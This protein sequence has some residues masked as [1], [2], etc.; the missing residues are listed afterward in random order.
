MPRLDEQLLTDVYG[1]NRK[2]PLTY[3]ERSYVDNL[4]REALAGQRHVVLYGGSKQGKTCL[5]RN[6]MPEES[7]IVVQAGGGFTIPKLY[8][9]I[10]KEAGVTVAVSEAKTVTGGTKLNVDLEGE[11]SIPFIAKAKGGV[12]G[13]R[14]K[15][16][17]LEATRR[18]I[19]IDPAD[20][21]DV[22]RILKEVGFSKYIV[23]EDFHYLPEETQRQFAFDLKVFHE[24][25]NISFIIV[26]VWLEAD[27]LLLYNGDL[28]ERVDAINVDRWD[29]HDLEAVIRSGE[30]LLNIAFAEPVVTKIV[31]ECQSNVGI[32]QQICKTMCESIGVV[33]TSPRAVR[34][35]HAEVVTDLVAEIAHRHAPRCENFLRDLVAGFQHTKLDIYRW[36][37]FAIVTAKPI[38]WKQGLNLNA[39]HRAISKN[40][41]IAREA[42]A[43]VPVN[44]V[45]N[46]LESLGRLQ[47]EK[48]VKPHILDFDAGSETLKIVDTGFTIWLMSEDQRDLRILVL[49]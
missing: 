35:G 31:D 28:Q 7:C 14:S 17:Q 1:V 5:R 12:K 45:R 40:H 4:F 48:H 49:S 9:S 39:I 23:I 37:A 43:D 15:G 25:S 41:P 47:F 22:V 13:E 42:K 8:E 27:R 29:R 16:S 6:C 2:M 32:L 19:D 26:G 24:K 34:L 18:S 36:I 30:P 3:V 21:N 38:Y 11:G 46:A 10:L 44:V 33:R 20:P